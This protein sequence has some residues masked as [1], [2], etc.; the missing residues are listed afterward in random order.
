M[1]SSRIP[2]SNSCAKKCTP[3]RRL[4]VHSAGACGPRVAQSAGRKRSQAVVDARGQSNGL[5]GLDQLKICRPP[6]VGIMGTN[7]KV[8]VM[9]L[10]LVYQVLDAGVKIPASECNA[11]SPLATEF[12]MTGIPDGFCSQSDAGKKRVPVNQRRDRIRHLPPCLQVISEFACVGGLDA[13]ET[14]FTMVYGNDPVKACLESCSAK[15]IGPGICV[16]LIGV[17]HI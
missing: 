4:R 11:E 10:L 3:A 8:G 2:G 17:C 7:G 1:N 16:Q 14:P 12:A 5:G 6:L 13:Q 15:A 9:K